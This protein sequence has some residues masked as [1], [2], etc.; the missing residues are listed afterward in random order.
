MRLTSY[1]PDQY[2]SFC[3]EINPSNLSQRR[4]II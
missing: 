1:S 3:S 2:F 4:S